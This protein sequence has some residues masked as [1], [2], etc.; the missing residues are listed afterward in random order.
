MWSREELVAQNFFE[1]YLENESFP[2]ELGR[3]ALAVEK[4]LGIKIFL[5]EVP[6]PYE[7]KA[8]LRLA[9]SS[10]LIWLNQN[11][12]KV[13][14]RFSGTHEFGHILMKHRNGIPSPGNSESEKE[15]ESANNFAAA[16]L[17]PA[18]EVACIAK[19]Y[20]D[21]LVFL[22]TKLSKYFGVNIEEAAKR[23]SKLDVLPGLFTLLNPSANQ[24][25]WEYHSPSV[26]LDH[27]AF[28][29]FLVY[30][31]QNPRK[32]EEDFDIMGYPFRVETKRVCGDK[33]LF[34][35]MPLLSKYDHVVS[36]GKK[37]SGYGK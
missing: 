17:M 7:V 22:I 9:R 28:A 1:G 19:K 36:G 10:A 8:H 12:S 11:H 33:V 14:Q 4:K 25:I 31:F 15:F 18:K 37:A 3:I 24:L 30:H 16:L 26:N 35:C 2:L 21:S 5:E 29:S 20:P 23:L 32:R 34:T 6:F 13:H 27:E